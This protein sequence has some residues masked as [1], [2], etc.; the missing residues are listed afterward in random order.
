M[1]TG[2]H[3][4]GGGGGGGNLAIDWH[5]SFPSGGGGNIPGRFMLQKPELSTSLMGLLAR[6][7]TLPLP[8]LCLRPSIYLFFRR[9][10]LA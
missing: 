10:L 7:R 3:N 6:M 8:C 2:A 4:A 5:D 1:G 9:I